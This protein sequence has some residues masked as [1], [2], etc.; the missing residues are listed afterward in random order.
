MSTSRIKLVTKK[1]FYC[2]LED[3]IVNKFMEELL[4]P[5]FLNFIKTYVNVHENTFLRFQINK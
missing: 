5:I 1:K 3:F 2:F 4:I